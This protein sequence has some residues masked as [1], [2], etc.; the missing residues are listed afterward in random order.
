M[1][2]SFT[3]KIYKVGINP[4]VEVPLRIT[5][6]MTVTKG[7]IPVKGQIGNHSFTQ[8][9]CPVKNAAY[10]LYVNGPMLKG[11]NTEVGDTVKFTIEQNEEPKTEAIYEMPKEFRQQLT[12]NKLQKA[13]TSLTPYRQ[14]EILKYLNSLK[15]KEALQRNIDKIVLGLKMNSKAPLLHKQER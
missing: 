6:K 7:Y 1:K 10:R 14:K 4:C 8:T 15:S 9:L 3:A 12:K 2:F 13:F 5:S 11:S